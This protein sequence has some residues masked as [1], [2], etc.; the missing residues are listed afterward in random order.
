MSTDGPEPATPPRSTSGRTELDSI[1]DDLIGRINQPVGLVIGPWPLAADTPGI[2]DDVHRALLM[3][4]WSD[5]RTKAAKLAKLIDVQLV[6]RN[7]Q[8]GADHPDGRDLGITVNGGIVGRML[9]D[10]QDGR[11]GAVTLVDIAVRPI[12]QRSGIGREVL[13]TLQRAAADAGRPVRVTA[14]F[15][16][17]ALRW[18]QRSGFTETGGDALYHHLEWRG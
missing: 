9:L 2:G 16:T 17:P 5:S 13:R 12:N 4:D 7:R 1:V 10:L 6:G 15:G 8:Y 14:V 11:S 18:F 3:E